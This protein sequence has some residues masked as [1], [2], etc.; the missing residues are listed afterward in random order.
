MVYPTPGLTGGK[1]SDVNERFLSEESFLGGQWPVAMTHGEWCW[2]GM[3]WCEDED[4]DAL[5]VV[6]EGGIRWGWWWCRRGVVRGEGGESFGAHHHVKRLGAP[7]G[8]TIRAADV[9]TLHDERKWL[10][11]RRLPA[12]LSNLNRVQMWLVAAVGMWKS[13]SKLGKF[14]SSIHMK[15]FDWIVDF[16]DFN[17]C[18]C[19]EG[20]FTV[21][22]RTA[23][24]I[25]LFRP[26]WRD[27]WLNE[28]NISLV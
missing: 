18:V 22:I 3:R 6:A 11:L 1:V 19:I 17:I 15:Y 2:S 25:L 20:R 12:R 10:S 21:V 27:F 8:W 5:V 23:R 14:I 9:R 4:E 24:K 7:E 28:M 26:E 16:P 13:N